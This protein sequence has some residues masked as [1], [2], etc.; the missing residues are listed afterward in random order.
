MCGR[1]GTGASCVGETNMAESKD[2]ESGWIPATRRPDGTWRKARRVKEGYVPPDEAEKYE[3]KGKQWLKSIPTLPPGVPENGD[4][5]AVKMSKNRKKNER[6]KQQRKE[7]KE[8]EQD[9]DD[10]IKNDGVE[11]IT[12]SL[13]D[14]SMLSPAE[15]LP[16]LDDVAKGKKIKNL[17]KKLRQ[18]EDLQTKID[19][20]E[21][22]ELTKEQ[23][24]KLQRK[25]D[26]EKELEGLEG[27]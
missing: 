27:T 21:V 22:K 6:K 3:S 12:V 10:G 26:L 11:D 9:K 13:Y 14:T 1:C 4:P 25:K 17:K 7:K 19:I 15:E 20:G 24:E 18:I 23:S 16:K 5:K 8:R 2:A